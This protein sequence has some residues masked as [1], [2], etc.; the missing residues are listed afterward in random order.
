MPPK[1]RRGIAGNH[2]IEEDAAALQRG[3]EALLFGGVARPGGGSQAEGGVVGDLDGFVDVLD[4]EE[5][6]D[7]AEELLAVDGRVARH[8][9]EDG[10]LEVVAFAYHAF[11]AGENARPRAKSRP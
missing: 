8:A 7:W 4:A 3:D 10:G 9:G 1:G 2:G 5:H 6:R 11:A